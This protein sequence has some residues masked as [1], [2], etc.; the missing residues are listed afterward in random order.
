MFMPQD[1]VEPYH[2]RRPIA[3]VLS[4]SLSWER[5]RQR[6][7]F[8]VSFASMVE[9]FAGSWHCSEAPAKAHSR[10]AAWLDCEGAS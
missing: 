1:H 3:N 7:F 8:A 9:V 2:D 4:Q 6:A 5:L 10:R